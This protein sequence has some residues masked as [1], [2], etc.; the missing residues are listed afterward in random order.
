MA[1]TPAVC[2]SRAARC[3]AGGQEL[4]GEEEEEHPAWGLV[5]GVHLLI[6]QHAEHTG[7]VGLRHFQR[8]P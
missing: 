5:P 3:S 7:D 2:W 8:A 1:E 4:K 6:R